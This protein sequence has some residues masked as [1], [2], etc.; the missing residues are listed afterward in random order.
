MVQTKDVVAWTI[1]KAIIKK[2]NQEAESS[3]RSRS[4]VAN[5]YLQ[6]VLNES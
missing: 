5:K 4:Y 2:I 3:D 1:D 6:E